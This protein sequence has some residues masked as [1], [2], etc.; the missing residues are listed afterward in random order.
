MLP[1]P[2][3]LGSVKCNL[4]YWITTTILIT[5]AADTKLFQFLLVSP[6]ENPKS[7]AAT[8]VLAV[9]LQWL[10]IEI[11]SQKGLLKYLKIDKASKRLQ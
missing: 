7:C 4:Q 6:N 3:S 9:K 1:E 8:N 11:A 5:V 10:D 2:T